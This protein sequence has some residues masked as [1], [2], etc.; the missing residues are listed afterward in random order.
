MNK[1]KSSETVLYY[2]SSALQHCSSVCLLTF[3]QRRYK[4][5]AWIFYDT[6]IGQFK[7]SL[8]DRRRR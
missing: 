2:N 6:W 1:K 7:V 3:E 5:D 4:S 8:H